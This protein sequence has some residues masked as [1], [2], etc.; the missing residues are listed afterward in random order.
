MKIILPV[1]FAILL[2]TILYIAFA[3]GLWSINPKT[4]GSYRGLFAI[5]AFVCMFGGGAIGS[6]VAD[7]SDKKNY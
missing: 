4:W 6:L 3:F 2:T 1:V 7:Y 5:L